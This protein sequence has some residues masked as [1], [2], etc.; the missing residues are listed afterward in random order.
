MS[1]RRTPS[2]LGLPPRMK[3]GSI[4][5]HRVSPILEELILDRWPHGGGY[6]V[7]A[8]KVGCDQSSIESIVDQDS[9]GAEFDLVDKLFCALGRVDVWR[10][11][12]ADVYESTQLLERCEHPDC[13]VLFLPS[14]HGGPRKRHCSRACTTSHLRGNRRIKHFKGEAGSSKCRNGHPRTPES[15]IFLKSG[16]I[17]CRV[18]NNATS[19]R[20]YYRKLAA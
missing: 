11:Q 1:D 10:G 2:T 3:P 4:P 13:S 17:R 19:L 5:T 20:G 12:I 14:P 15:T 6:D 18:C 7:L 8:E 9:P 16:R